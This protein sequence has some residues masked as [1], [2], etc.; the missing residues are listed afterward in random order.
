MPEKLLPFLNE[1]LP[2]NP[3]SN[4]VPT[5]TE[6]YS[7]P[8]PVS[9]PVDNFLSSFKRGLGFDV[10]QT[11]TNYL[12]SD[13]LR[14]Q[15]T[16]AAKTIR[17]GSA[18]IIF[19]SILMVLL[20]VANLIF[21]SLLNQ[22]KNEQVN[23]VSKLTDAA[24]AEKQ[25]LDISKRIDYY[26]QALDSRKPLTAKVSFVLSRINPVVDLLDAEFSS[27]EFTVT[28]KSNTGKDITD[29]FMLWLK[30][31]SVTQVSIKSASLDPST[32]KYTVILGG[33]Y[34]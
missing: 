23:L 1:D 22:A 3:Q 30:D 12:E 33:S 7:T 19:V 17:V 6:N 32:K 10:S 21:N 5:P 27:N 16:T 13:S 28:L 2:K 20:V 14:E 26:K 8:V 29:T 9:S 4:I 15:L 25:V 24:Q 34:R 31:G 18:L 11:E